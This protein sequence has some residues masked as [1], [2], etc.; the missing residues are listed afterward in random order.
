MQ[1]S[2]LQ[3][4]LIFIFFSNFEGDVISVNMSDAKVFDVSQSGDFPKSR[5]LKLEM[6]W[7]LWAGLVVVFV[8]LVVVPAAAM[9]A[10]H[11]QVTS[12]GYL[13]TRG[14]CL[15]TPGHEK[16]G[17]HGEGMK[18]RRRQ[19][20]LSGRA[21]GPDVVPGGGKDL[22]GYYAGAIQ[23]SGDD[24]DPSADNA[25]AASSE[26]FRKKRELLSSG[27]NKHSENALE[28]IA[29]GSA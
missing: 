11:F 16:C 1:I 19:G 8:L 9:S 25:T 17:V 4:P 23:S 12:A 10:E 3:P 2:E 26:H 21:D 13:A 28:S 29:R 5:S 27:P 6:H 7:G 14:Q 20:F 18:G 24:S 15:D 22:A